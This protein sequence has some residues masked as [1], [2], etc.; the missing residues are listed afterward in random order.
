MLLAAARF[1]PLGI[2][3]YQS[4]NAFVLAFSIWA[5]IAERAQLS[6]H[7]TALRQVGEIDQA[8]CNDPM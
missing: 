4:P 3:L 7:R 6:H 2:G 1:I 8:G 5:V